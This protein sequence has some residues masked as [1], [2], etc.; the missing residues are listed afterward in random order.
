MH[1]W[2]IR[3]ALSGKGRPGD[4]ELPPGLSHT[5][6]TLLQPCSQLVKVNLPPMY[7]CL[8]RSRYS[9]IKLGVNWTTLSG[10]Q[11]IFLA[12]C[13]EATSDAAEGTMYGP[14]IHTGFSGLQ[15]NYLT[16]SCTISPTHHIHFIYFAC[17]FTG[18]TQSALMS[19]S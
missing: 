18:H 8:L 3:A 19:Y 15:N 7:L 2:T 17:L 16:S 5:S 14:L 4:L 9:P 10:S 12:P 1:K 11:K 13:S 6:H